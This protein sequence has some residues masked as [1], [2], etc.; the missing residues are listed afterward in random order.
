MPASAGVWTNSAGRTAVVAEGL[1]MDE[2][3]EKLDFSEFEEQYTGG[4]AYIKRYYDWFDRPL[5]EGPIKELSGQPMK[6]I[7]PSERGSTELKRYLG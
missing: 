6:A 2:I 4:D 3:Q 5:R 7:K 1:S